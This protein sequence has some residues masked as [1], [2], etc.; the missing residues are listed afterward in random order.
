MSQ[1]MEAREAQLQ[2]QLAD[3][4]HFTQVL[5][6]TRTP[7]WAFQPFTAAIQGAEI[8]PRFLEPAIGT[9]NG[10]GDPQSHMDAF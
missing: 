2:Q 3:M 8:P 1:A 10:T 6:A 9:Y 4:Q 5:E 7:L